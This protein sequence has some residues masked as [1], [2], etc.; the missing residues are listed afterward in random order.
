M[1]EREMCHNFI[2]QYHEL[3]VFDH[4]EQASNAR[5]QDNLDTSMT[6]QK[7]VEKHRSKPTTQ[8]DV[9]S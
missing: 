8:R 3:N 1:M 2:N 7:S 9:I 4:G 5:T 6:H